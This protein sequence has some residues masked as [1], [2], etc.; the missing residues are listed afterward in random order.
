MSENSHWEGDNNQFTKINGGGTPWFD[1]P[2]TS[3]FEQ[4]TYYGD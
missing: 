2:L 4:S 3:E 1:R